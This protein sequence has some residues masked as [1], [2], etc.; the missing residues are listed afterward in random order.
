[1]LLLRSLAGLDLAE[2]G[3]TIVISSNPQLPQAAVDAFE[4]RLRVKGF[5][6]SARTDGNGDG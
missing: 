2:I 1:L 5:T 3:V 6:G 4:Q